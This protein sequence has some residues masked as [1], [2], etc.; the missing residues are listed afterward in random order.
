MRSCHHELEI[1]DAAI[2]TFARLLVVTGRRLKTHGS[3]DG[4][5]ICEDRTSPARPTLWK[6]SPD[7]GL[8]PDSRYNYARRAFAPVALPTSI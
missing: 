7:G 4:G 5:M 6:I 1:T 8:V 2:G 3:G